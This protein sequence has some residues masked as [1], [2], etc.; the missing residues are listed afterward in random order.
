DS[1]ETDKAVGWW[2]NV[3]SMDVRKSGAW[4][5]PVI[6]VNSL[7]GEEAGSLIA[8]IDDHERHM[9]DS[10]EWE[11]RKKESIRTEVRLFLTERLLEKVDAKIADNDMSKLL[12]RMT[13]PLAYIDKILKKKRRS[14]R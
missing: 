9:K 2:K 12:E 14:K 3:L 13:D 7:S 1:E 5:M 6:A 11:R 10:G 4:K 8:A